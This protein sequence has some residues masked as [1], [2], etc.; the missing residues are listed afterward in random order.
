MRYQLRLR[1]RHLGK[2][3][4]QQLCCPLVILLAGALQL[5]LKVNVGS[6]NE[7]VDA[8]PGGV[9]QRLGKLEEAAEVLVK[10]GDI[11]KRL[12]NDR[13]RA[14]CDFQSRRSLSDD[15]E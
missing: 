9:L 13:G 5:V 15:R 14:D 11:E 2:A 4:F 1:A 8:G 3:V 7:G 12:G 6:S 10:A